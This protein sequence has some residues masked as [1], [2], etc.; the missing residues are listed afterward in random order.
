MAN[1]SRPVVY[2]TGELVKCKGYSKVGVVD[3]NTGMASGVNRPDMCWINFYEFDKPIP[4]PVEEVRRLTFTEFLWYRDP[5]TNGFKIGK[6]KAFPIL[7]SLVFSLFVIVSSFGVDG[8]AKFVTMS[9]GLGIILINYLGVRKNWNG[10]W[11]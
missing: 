2:K 11:V 4:R 8:W 1:L 6:N 9:I 3:H 10:K 7:F 5:Q